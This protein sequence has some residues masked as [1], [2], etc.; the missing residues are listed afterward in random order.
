[1][2]RPGGDHDAAAED[3]GRGLA[4][5]LGDGVV[6]FDPEANLAW[7]NDAFCRLIGLSREDLLGTSALDRVHPEELAQALDGIDYSKQFPGRTSIAPFRIRRGDGEWL[8]IELKTQVLDRPD[9]EYLALVV[10]DGTS[11]QSINR[12]LRS[13]A[14]GD[15]FE[16]TAALTVDVIARRWPDL[17]SAVTFGGPEGQE[18]VAHGLDGALIDHAR[19]TL[20][21]PDVA[22]PWDAADVDGGIVIIP[23][24]E[25]APRLAA[26]AEAAGFEGCAIARIVDPGGPPCC[27]VVWF[28]H[29]IIA[30]LEFRHAAVEI[31]EILSLALDRRH[32]SWQLWHLARHDALTG[33][34]NRIGFF[35][36]FE[37][38]QDLAEPA[39]GDALA[40][41]YVDL[42]DLKRVNDGEGHARGD[43]LLIQTAR[44]IVDAVGA[45][46][47]VARIGGDEFVVAAHF[48]IDDAR[49]RA[50][51]LADAIA[52]GLG[53]SVDD[54]LGATT[55]SI[56]IVIDVAA[57]GASRA[58]ELADAAMYRA[59]AAG[60]A[61]SSF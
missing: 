9:G 61:R 38:G 46:A 48:P 36:R 21:D 8:D 14:S 12:A 55:A 57:M 44:L 50:E 31:C 28:D 25:M 15:P 43:H 20:A 30:R 5:A 4:A 60:K 41:L 7:V 26:A 51:A 16:E 13:V 6:V 32:R 18:V 40:L 53:S 47:L 42:D 54:D 24:S 19:G 23:R 29:L 17:G 59:K 49:A 52:T 11:R 3:L 27:V 2:T 10:R 34:L 37:P 35:E 33:V 56:G 58:I 39:P 22:T 1:M 45:D